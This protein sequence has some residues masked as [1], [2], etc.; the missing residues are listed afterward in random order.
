MKKFLSVMMLVLVVLLAFTGCEKFT[1]SDSHKVSEL[2]GTWTCI[3]PEFAEA[4]VIKSNGSV[5]STGYDGEYWEDIKGNISIQDGKIA[6]IFEDDDNL[7]GHFD[8]IPGIAFSVTSED[9]KRYT[10]NYCKEDL[11]DEIVGMWV[12]ND[13]TNGT[14]NQ[15]AINTYM[16]DGTNVFTG[17]VPNTDNYMLN[18]TTKYKVVGDLMFKQRADNQVPDGAVKYIFARLMYTPNATLHGDI[19]SHK[20]YITTK[21]ETSEIVLSYLRIN[22]NLDLAGKK[23]DY[24]ATYMSNAKGQDKDITFLNTKF[25]F[26]KMNGSIIDKFLKSVLYGVQFP[27]AKTFEYNCLLEGKNVALQLPMEVDGNKITI[28]MSSRNAA[29]RDIDVYAFQ[30]ED[31]SQFHMYMPTSTFENF[32]GNLSLS[33]L[34]AS[35]KVDINNPVHV[36]AVYKEVVDA[37]ESIN[38]SIVMK[39][40][41]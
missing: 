23:Y 16:E 25:N 11:S 21:N 28:K 18:I 5:L 2:A 40:S 27:N 17:V 20:Q 30:D 6:M 14:T 36:E 33:I 10:Y 4:L 29:Y 12:C 32:F 1:C 3:Q 7:E 15:M 9:G 41:K 37:I 22:Q 39:E 34:S 31:C 26:A 38:V 24:S 8:F 19:M 13:A 35:G